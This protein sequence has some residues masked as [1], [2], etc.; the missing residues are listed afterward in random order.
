MCF[1]L[2]NTNI[3][4]FVINFVGLIEYKYL[5]RNNNKYIII[6]LCHHF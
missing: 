6:E 3:Y 1:V 2:I 5:Y 4:I